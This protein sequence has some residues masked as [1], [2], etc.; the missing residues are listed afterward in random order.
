MPV[1]RY[2]KIY[3]ADSNNNRLRIFNYQ[4]KLKKILTGYSYPRGVA[5][6]GRHIF[7]AEPFDGTVAVGDDD[8]EIGTRFNEA[9]H[10]AAHEAKKDVMKYPTSVFIDDHNRLYVTEFGKSR[11]LVYSL[12]P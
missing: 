10:E 3:V 12:E 9:G 11:V 6:T 4:G 5:L 2:G 7:T 8:G 1:D